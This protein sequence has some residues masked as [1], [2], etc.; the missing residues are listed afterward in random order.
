MKKFQEHLK[1]IKQPTRKLG[2]SLNKYQQKN[3]RN[4]RKCK[5]SK[6]IK[7]GLHIQAK[8]NEMEESLIEANK[9][10]KTYSKN[11]TTKMNRKRV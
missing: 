9:Q 2:I 10:K 6:L 7:E 8:H 5:R 1:K 11:E 3:Q 4:G